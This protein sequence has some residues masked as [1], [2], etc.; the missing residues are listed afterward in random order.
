MTHDYI[1]SEADRLVRAAKSRDPYELAE[2]DGAFVREADLGSLKG[3][4]TVVLGNPFI[5]INRSLPERTKKIICA[6]ELG[7]HRLHRELA[8]GGVHMREFMLYKMDERPEYEANI[9]AAYLLLDEK[10]IQ[11]MAREG[12]DVRAIAAAL[13]SDVNLVLIMIDE[14]A[15]AGYDLRAMPRPRSDFLK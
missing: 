8:E 11:S 6:H 4:Y 3:M 2:L 9:F 14:M 12:M 13:H 7:H 15:R 5:I 10:E 1:K